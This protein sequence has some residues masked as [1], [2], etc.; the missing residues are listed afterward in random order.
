MISHEG[1]VL[2]NEISALIKETLERSLV[3]VLAFPAS[4]TVRNKCLQLTNHPFY[5]VL[6][7]GPG[8]IKTT[9]IIFLTQQFHFSELS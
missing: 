6:L 9:G 5:D 1:G 8:R 7:E 4:R 3:L 2:I